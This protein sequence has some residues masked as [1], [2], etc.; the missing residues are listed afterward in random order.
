MTE[1]G[2][3][4]MKFLKL[5]LF[6][7]TCGLLTGCHDAP[8]LSQSESERESHES[9]SG[10]G[11][12]EVTANDYRVAFLSDTHLYDWDDDFLAA[13]L[14]GMNSAARVNFA[15]QSILREQEENHIA[16]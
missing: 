4:K 10:G 1:Y 6:V 15:V 3:M 9:S 11:A 16:F 8:S 5:L 14:F 13:D 7:L 12:A 2:Q